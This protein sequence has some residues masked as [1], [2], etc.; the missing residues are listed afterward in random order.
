MARFYSRSVPSSLL[1]VVLL[2]TSRGASATWFTK[3]QP[4]PQWGLDAAKTKVPDYAKDAAAVI[5]SDEYVETIDAQGRALEREREAIRILKPQ[6]RGNSCEVSY[7][8]T[9]KVHYFRVWT[10]AADEKQYQAQ[11]SDFAERGD[12]D[13]PIMLSTRKSKLVHAPAVDVGA[14]IICESEELMEPY[15]QEK[16]WSIQTGVPVVFEALEVNVPA[17]R[18]VTNSWHSHEPVP[19]LAGGPTHWRWELKDVPALTLRDVPSAPA[20]EAL[21]GRMT[22]QW[23]EAA[24][25]GMDQQWR[26][27]GKWVTN[28][29]ADRTTPS[30]EI[31]AKAQDLVSSA[32][33]FYAKLSRITSS[34]QKDVRYFIVM[35]GIGGLQANHAADIFRNRYGDCKDK[36]TLLISMLQTAGIRA[37]YVPVD[38]RRGV[39]DP[40]DPS[41]IGDHMIVAIEIPADVHDPRL[42][43]VVTAKNGKRYLIF[44]PTDERTPVGNLGSGLQGSFGTLAA[45]DESQVIQLP[46]LP[47]ESNGTERK[48]SF[49]LTIDGTL[50][51]TVDSFHTGPEG[52]DLRMALKYS[53]EKERKQ[54]FET[55]ITHDLPGAQID[56]LEF[57]QSLELEKPME[58]HFKL[59]APQYAHNMGEL[60][61]VR[62]HIVN[63]DMQAFDSKP[64]TVPIDLNATG[65]WHDSFDITIPAGYAVDEMPDAVDLDVD[66]AKYHS[67][68]SAKGNLLHYEREY[69]VRQVQIPADKAPAFRKLESTIMTDEKGTAVLKKQLQAN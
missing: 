28:L 33:D 55:L 37:F 11:E 22:V 61:L 57:V 27:I 20:W 24:V 10:I 13:I 1:L 31:T 19:A 52:A 40:N 32:P 7:D 68:I 41:L 36:S 8:E 12:T 63:S 43:A 59:S 18:S 62:P 44:D 6:G 47:P 3:G 30:P 53:D 38:H 56:S 23:G 15:I 50:M 51:G 29:E 5:L 54:A 58:V 17:T 21:A 60:L 45:G 2:F 49:T 4:I 26:A 66:F 42:Q 39:V 34:I 46:V 35:R 16:I 48:G 67:S 69:I 65:R 25:A 14:T 64:R 9:E